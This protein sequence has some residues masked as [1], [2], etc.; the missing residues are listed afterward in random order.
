MVDLSTC[1]PKTGVE[2]ADI[3]R[4]FGFQVYLPIRPRP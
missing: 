4:R 2:L 3:V 1:P